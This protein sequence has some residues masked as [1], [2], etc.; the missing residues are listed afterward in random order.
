MINDFL[1]IQN[2]VLLVTG[3]SS[4]IG[5]SI[6][7]TCYENG[8]ML[9]LLGRDEKKMAETT[10]GMEP[11]S[12]YTILI[13]LKK[14]KELEETINIAV[15]QMGKISGFCHSAG[16]ER[17]LPIK[18]MKPADY[19][20]LFS[21]NAVAGFELA[22]LLS[23]K[24]YCSEKGASFIFISSVSSIVG[25]AGLAAYSASKG[26]IVSVTKAMAIE[27]ANRNIR[28]NSVSPGTV[29]TPLVENFIEKLDSEHKAQRLSDYPLG[30]GEPEDVANLVA[31][32]LS[33]RSKWITGSN[34]IIDGGYTAK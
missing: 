12:F 30:I 24:K 11:G 21:V 15:Q 5:R 8:A 18:T 19:M 1:D 31:F 16:Y 27:L 13:D 4:G 6:A 23:K 26:A 25:R 33:K 28:V 14:Y 17:T 10:A 3:A 34:I 7:K 2:K 29:M 20:D 9:I 32:L 22:R